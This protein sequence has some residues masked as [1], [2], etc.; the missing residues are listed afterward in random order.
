MRV[1]QICSGIVIVDVY[2][3]CEPILEDTNLQG[4]DKHVYVQGEYLKETA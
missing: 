3:H 4:L 1:V 2:V